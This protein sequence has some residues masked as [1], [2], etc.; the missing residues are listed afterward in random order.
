MKKLNVKQKNWLVSAHVIS[1]ATWFGTA[2]CMVAIS[3]KNIG[4]NN[5]DMLY[6]INSILKTLDDFVI[7]PT[8]IASL[9]TGALLSWLTIWGFFKHYWVIAK[10]IGTVTLITIGTIWLGPWVNAITSISETERVQALTN[11]LYVFDVQ[12]A[13]IGG[14]I[15]TLSVAFIIAI[16]ILKPW[17]KRVTKSIQVEE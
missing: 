6:A 16:S 2:I 14:A 13:L 9:L 12:A 8:A 15:Q 1:G 10:W 5:G 7:I 3:L 17:G 4:N 11:P